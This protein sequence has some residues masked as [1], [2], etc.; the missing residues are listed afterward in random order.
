MIKVIKFRFYG[1]ESGVG[2]CFAGNA[3]QR[4]RMGMFFAANAVRVQTDRIRT[5][6]A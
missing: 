3:E 4:F 1:D 6:E 2:I 5:T